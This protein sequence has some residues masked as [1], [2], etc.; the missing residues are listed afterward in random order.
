MFFF[1]FR[2]LHQSEA[3]HQ[4]LSNKSYPSSFR[5]VE[6]PI[7]LD[8]TP[9]NTALFTLNKKWLQR[10]LAEKILSQIRCFIDFL[11]FFSDFAVVTE[12]IKD[13]STK[14]EKDAASV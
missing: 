7:K 3:C 6:Y 11:I 14:A 12:R 9:K 8:W 13:K 2:R 4:E 5:C 10:S 1:F